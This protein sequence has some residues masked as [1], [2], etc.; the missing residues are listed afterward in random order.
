MAKP[1]KPTPTLY[2]EEAEEFARKARENETK[3]HNESISQDDI[4]LFLGVLKNSSNEFK[5]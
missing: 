1:I 5:F 3:I 2:D 4:N